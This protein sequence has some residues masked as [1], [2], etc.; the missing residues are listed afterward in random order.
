MKATP[1]VPDVPEATDTW[2]AKI[3][4][5]ASAMGWWV[6]ASLMCTFRVTSGNRKHVLALTV[7]QR[8]AG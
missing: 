2:L 8:L 1:S 3:S 5:S 4:M 6:L 7:G